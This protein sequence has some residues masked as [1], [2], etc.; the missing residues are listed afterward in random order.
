MKKYTCQA[1]IRGILVEDN[2]QAVSS[3]QAWYKFCEKNG[4]RCRDFKIIGEEPVILESNEKQL[5]FNI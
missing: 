2:V 3:R 1:V 5:S 4:Y